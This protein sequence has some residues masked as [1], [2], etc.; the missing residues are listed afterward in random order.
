MIMRKMILI[1]TAVV[2]IFGLLAALGLSSNHSEDQVEALSTANNL[3]LSGNYFE[4]VGLYE[5]IIHQGF[6]DSTVYF[7]LGNAY[8]QQGDHGRALLNFKRAHQ[9]NPR[10][11]DIENN[12][13][14]V[15]AEIASGSDSPVPAVGPQQT[16]A[17]ITGNLLTVNESSLLSL[18]LWFLIFFLLL[19][20]RTMKPGRIR[21]SLGY[22]T[23]LVIVMFTLSS[24]SLVSR[25]FSEQNQ[26]DAIVIAPQASV[27]SQ[28]DQQ[29]PTP[30][31]LNNGTQIKLLDAY[32]D[33][34]KFSN[35][36]NTISGWIPASTVEMVSQN[37]PIN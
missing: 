7:N 19:L 12:I 23:I 4:A 35:P 8:Y 31:T 3:Y 24:F 17:N 27:T 37:V 11:S 34:I 26:P 22:L 16:L 25:I 28:P 1:L 2:M 15:E 18:G 30:H 20:F 21:R 10:D 6:E 13:K 29:T 33:W 36:G 9:L 5:Q 32:G 14:I